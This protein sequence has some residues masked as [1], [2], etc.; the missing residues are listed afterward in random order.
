MRPALRFAA[1]VAALPPLVPR[2][3]Y[4]AGSKFA[5]GHE[6]HVWPH[7]PLWPANSTRML[8]RTRIG[9]SATDFQERHFERD[10]LATLSDRFKK[11]GK[12]ALQCAEPAGLALRTAVN[13]RQRKKKVLLSSPVQSQ[14]VDKKRG[15]TG[16]ASESASE[17]KK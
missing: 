9:S 2:N 15:A 4:L 12:V 17:R 8:L 10:A 14:P 16:H 1:C 6:V 7:N 11:S 3:A 5:N 13:G